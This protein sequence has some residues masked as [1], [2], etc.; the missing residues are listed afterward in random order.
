M[1]ED[2]LR[3]NDQHETKQETH[4][5]TTF[6]RYTKTNLSETPFPQGRIKDEIGAAL[7]A[8]P[9]LRFGMRGCPSH[10]LFLHF[11]SCLVPGG[12]LNSDD[13][14]GVREQWVLSSEN[15]GDGERI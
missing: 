4:K 3:Y 12:I 5:T 9:D 8:Q 14:N 1:A 7:K 11:A 15:A 2:D 6:I 10:R 13:S